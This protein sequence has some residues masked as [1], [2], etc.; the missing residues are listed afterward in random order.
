M[1]HR[2]GQ[3]EA[4]PIF[5]ARGIQRHLGAMSVAVK[6]GEESDGAHCY[7]KRRSPPDGDHGTEHDHRKRD[8]D[9][10]KRN[11]HP[12]DAEKAAERHE[13]YEGKRHEPQRASAELIGEETDQ[14]H[15]ELMIETA[16]RMHEAASESARAADAD[17]G[18][19]GGRYEAKREDC[20]LEK[21]LHGKS[22]SQ[23]ANCAH[24]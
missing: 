24:S 21:T 14:D 6:D 13:Y 16:Q 4:D 11:R 5:K 15:G 19:R 18:D 23:I 3:H 1:Q 10:D 12:H 8:A 2:R 20:K 17:M 9:L 7:R 22:P